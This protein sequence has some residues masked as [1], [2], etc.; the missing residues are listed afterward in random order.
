MDHPGFSLMT[1]LGL[2]KIMGACIINCQNYFY[3]IIIIIIINNN[4]KYNLHIIMII[5]VFHKY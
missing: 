2:R 3:T 1:I 4:Y 5:A